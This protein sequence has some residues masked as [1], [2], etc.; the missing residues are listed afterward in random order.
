MAP[1]SACLIHTVSRAQVRERRPQSQ[2]GHV[3]NK[4]INIYQAIG[5]FGS[6]ALCYFRPV[7]VVCF[8]Y[9][10]A[11]CC[12]LVFLKTRFANPR[13][14]GLCHPVARASPQQQQQYIYI[15]IYVYKKTYIS[16]YI[17]IYTM[18]KRLHLQRSPK[19]PHGG[20]PP[21]FHFGRL[22]IR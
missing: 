2:K 18:S 11:F 14:R 5:I 21:L 12:F 15:Y 10:T 17:Y 9:E 22:F 16:I 20:P 7:F 13:V 3:D 19:S 4:Y 8:V 1:L 6:I